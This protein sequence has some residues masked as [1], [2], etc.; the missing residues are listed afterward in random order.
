MNK[1]LFLSLMIV[2]ALF[3]SILPLA[4]EEQP[5][6]TNLTK[7]Y[8]VWKNKGIKFVVRKDDGTF[9]GWGVGRLE[10]W[11]GESKWVVRNPKGQFMVHAKGEVEKWK[12]GKTRLVLRTNKGQLLTHINIA[13]TSKGSFAENVV[14]LRRLENDKFLAFVQE[15][16][17]E[18]IINDLKDGDL[19]KARV[20]A[21]YLAKYK[22]EAGADHFVPVLKTILRQVN[23]MAG[24]KPEPRLVELQTQLRDLLKFFS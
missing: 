5:T 11:S 9:A 22:K 23:F 6:V 7:A 21:Q 15:S 12:N 10:S 1:R 16:I 4:A 18:L 8:E 19:V 2:F 14:G 13:I 24:E 20:L 17:S 3:L